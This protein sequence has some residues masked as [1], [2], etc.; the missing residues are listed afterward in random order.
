MLLEKSTPPI[1]FDISKNLLQAINIIEDADVRLGMCA[2]VSQYAIRHGF[3]AKDIA[4]LDQFLKSLNQSGPAIAAKIKQKEQAKQALTSQETE[5]KKTCKTILLLE[6]PVA[7]KAT[8]QK[9][10]PQKYPEEVI[11]LVAPQELKQADSAARLTSYSGIYSKQELQQHL[12]IL[13]KEILAYAKKQ[14]VTDFIP[15]N[16][17]FGSCEHAVALR[18]DI[19]TDQWLM[20]NSAKMPIYPVSHKNIGN[21][22]SRALQLGGANNTIEMGTIVYTTNQCSASLTKHFISSLKENPEFK[23]LHTVTQKKAEIKTE[24]GLNWLNIATMYGHIEEVKSLLKVITNAKS[25]PIIDAAYNGY[26]DILKMLLLNTTRQQANLTMLYHAIKHLSPE[27]REPFIK[28]FTPNELYQIIVGGNYKVKTIVAQVN[29]Y[30]SESDI[31]RYLYIA[32]L[33]AYRLYR[34]EKSVS[35]VRWATCGGN[36]KSTQAEAFE[37]ALFKSPNKAAQKASLVDSPLL[38]KCTLG[39]LYK[40]YFKL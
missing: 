25:L 30:K 37:F 32:I 40:N 12:D 6:S 4:P 21:E 1:K 34:D 10:I 22:L 3:L 36:D 13:K 19:K 20:L 29:P 27:L 35:C 15:L 14:N 38:H 26:L 9:L 5:F 28:L 31:Y 18:Y 11:A 7:Y 2:G 23:T 16:F 17:E 24:A 33:Q 8:L 39:K